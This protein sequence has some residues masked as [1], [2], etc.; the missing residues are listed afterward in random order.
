MTKK[1]NKCGKKK[2]IDKFHKAPYGLHNRVG[3]CKDCRKE[4]DKKYLQ[5]KKIEKDFERMFV[6]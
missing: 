3:T 4:V 2:N 1:C 5:N 6:G